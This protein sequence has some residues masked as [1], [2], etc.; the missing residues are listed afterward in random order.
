M[1]ADRVLRLVDVVSESIR[2][3]LLDQRCATLVQLLDILP[4]RL[5]T[6]LVVQ[7]IK[8]FTP[9]AEVGADHENRL[10]IA[11]IRRQNSTE[12]ETKT[13]N[14]AILDL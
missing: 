5:R 6:V 7:K 3:L 14:G 1:P 12:E 9:M 11:K 8:G 2:I 10:G 4:D 13:K